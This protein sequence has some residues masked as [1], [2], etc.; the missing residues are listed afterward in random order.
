VEAGVARGRT[1]RV[2]VTLTPK[3]PDGKDLLIADVPGPAGPGDVSGH[4]GR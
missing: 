3:R 2:K 4:I 1:H